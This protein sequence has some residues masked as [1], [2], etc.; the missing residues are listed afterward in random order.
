MALDVEMRQTITAQFNDLKITVHSSN[1][2]T[3]YT[4][5]NIKPQPRAGGIKQEN[6]QIILDAQQM[7][8]LVANGDELLSLTKRNDDNGSIF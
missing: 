7:R 8:S 5:T 1:V 3:T 2:E 6:R 4:I